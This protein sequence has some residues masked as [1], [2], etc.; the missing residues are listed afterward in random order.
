MSLQLVDGVG[1]Q[2]GKEASGGAWGTLSGSRGCI[3]VSAG[4]IL[5]FC[6]VLLVIRASRRLGCHSWL[7]DNFVLF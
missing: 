5:V 2:G 7:S 6:R 3:L 4:N 1:G